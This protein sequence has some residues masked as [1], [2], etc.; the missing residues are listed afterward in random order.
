MGR[1]WKCHDN[2]VNDLSTKPDR[3]DTIGDESGT[4]IRIHSKKTSYM[5]LIREEIVSREVRSNAR[6]A[7]SQQLPC[8]TRSFRERKTMADRPKI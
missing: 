4:T 2:D 7:A 8:A 3:V 6:D 1:V 5:A